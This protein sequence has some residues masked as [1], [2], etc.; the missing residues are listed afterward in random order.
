[1]KWLYACIAG[2][3]LTLSAASTANAQVSWGARGYY[4]PWMGGGYYGGAYSPGG[5][6]TTE[7]RVT[8]PGLAAT[9]KAELS[10][11]RTWEPGDMAVVGT[12]PGADAMAIVTAFGDD[13]KLLARSV[14]EGGPRLCF[15]LV[16]SVDA[17][18]PSPIIT[19]SI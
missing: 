11:I 9:T 13:K 15:G 10:P 2:V 7:V 14:S 3:V 17:S 16:N 12:V 5:A 8:T 6:A 18:L 1:M 19:I 4:N